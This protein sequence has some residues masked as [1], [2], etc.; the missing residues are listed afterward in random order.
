MSF[1]TTPILKKD[2]QTNV[3][4]DSYQDRAFRGTYAG[5]NITY[6]A[7]ARPGTATSAAAW[8]IAF[9][10][11]DESNNLVSITWPK[12]PQ[13]NASSEYIFVWD[14]RASYTYV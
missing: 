2:A 12:N 13:G 10:T 11:Y 6:R 8:Q 5:T 14:D 3:I 7:Y 4:Q 9:F 1:Q